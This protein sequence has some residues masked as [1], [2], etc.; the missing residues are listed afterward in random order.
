MS[1]LFPFLVW[2]HLTAAIAWIGGMMFLSLVLAPLVRSYKTV[3]EFIALFR[4]AALRFRV[5][6][7]TAVALLLGTGPLLLDHRGLSL[8]DPAG[9]P[10]VLRVKLALVGAL[11]A[12]ILAHDLLQASQVR[13]ISSIPE[14]AR[15]PWEQAIVRTSSWVP[16]V[17]LLLALGVLFAAVVLSRS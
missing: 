17:A 11:V 10:Q 8:F 12:L 5:V 4:T 15:S 1:D 16:R 6:V 13:K 2:L 9:W 14:S 3:S 7:W